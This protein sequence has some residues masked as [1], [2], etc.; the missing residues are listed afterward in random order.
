MSEATGE[1]QH[2][3]WRVDGTWGYLAARGPRYLQG[4]TASRSGSQPPTVFLKIDGQPGPV[5][6]HYMADDDF[7]RLGYGNARIFSFDVNRLGPIGRV[8]LS[9]HFLD[10][11]DTIDNGDPFVLD[12][13][14]ASPP[15]VPADPPPPAPAID[16]KDATGGSP[17]WPGSLASIDER[18]NTLKSETQAGFAWL[19]PQLSALSRSSQQKTPAI[20][21]AT[22]ATAI[23]SLLCSASILVYLLA[24]SR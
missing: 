10:S 17:S 7:R 18:I 19:E 23:I 11:G 1:R 9:V 16:P 14:D 15:A 8:S 22:F 6:S 4:T 21:I 20:L 24:S 3:L 13:P 12:L 5:I 2:P